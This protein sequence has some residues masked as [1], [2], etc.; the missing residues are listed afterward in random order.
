[1]PVLLVWGR[2]DR[3]ISIS[4]FNELSQKIPNVQ[5]TV[6]ENSGH[7]PHEEE[8]EAFNARLLGFLD[9]LS[10]SRLTPKPE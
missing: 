10:G 3:Q 8:P 7:L 5:T 2:H 9:E 1:M 6:F 4:N